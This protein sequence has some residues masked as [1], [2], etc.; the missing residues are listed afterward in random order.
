MDPVTTIPAVQAEAPQRARRRPRAMLAALIL[1][2][3]LGIMGVGATL[4]A[5]ESAD[6]SASPSTTTEQSDGSTESGT[7]SGTDTD[8]EDCPE[9]SD[10][11]A[12]ESD[13]SSS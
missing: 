6:P 2:G 3:A 12:T 8:G 4:A 10:D 1:A 5:D 7:D 11:A 13:A 9:D